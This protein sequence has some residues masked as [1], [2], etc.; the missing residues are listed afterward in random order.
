M[1]IIVKTQL[2]NELHDFYFAF[3]P[4]QGAICTAV[5]STIGRIIFSELE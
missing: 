1:I 5:N 2:Y 4:S 3:L